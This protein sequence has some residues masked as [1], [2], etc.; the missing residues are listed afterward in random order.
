MFLGLGRDLK[1]FDEKF[2]FALISFKHGSA[3]VSEDSKKLE[4]NCLKKKK[5]NEKYLKKKILESSETHFDRH[6]KNQSKFVF[7]K[8]LLRRLRPP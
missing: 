4:K 7:K 3:Y 8:V 1:K 2:S 6:K 5:F